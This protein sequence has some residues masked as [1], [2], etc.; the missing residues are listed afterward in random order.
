MKKIFAN[1]ISLTSLPDISNWNINN[2]IKMNEIFYNCSSLIS[3]P[4]LSKWNTYKVDN[5]RKIF[6][7]CSS[8]SSLPDM[9][10]WNKNLINFHNTCYNCISLLF[11]P[12]KF[13]NINESSL[14]TILNASSSSVDT[15][16]QIF[17]FLDSEFEYT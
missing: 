4:D 1:C 15:L 14:S 5:M 9:S 7:N 8:I 13:I 12:S 17:D 3:L 6:Y 11:L 2:V 16:E 10:N